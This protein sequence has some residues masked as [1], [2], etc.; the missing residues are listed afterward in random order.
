M[1][2]E[3]SKFI[4]TLEK[5]GWEYLYDSDRV[6]GD[7]PK[8]SGVYCFVRYDLLECISEIVYV[9]KAKDFSTRLRPWHRI[10][11]LFDRQK[12]YLFCYILKTTNQDVLEIKYIKK[13]CPM[14]NIQHNPKITR[15]ITYQYG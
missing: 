11:N 10:E 1:V 15:I 12:G 2:N 9:G 6:Y 3:A 8:Q 4:D 5:S 14:F 7:I 13:Y